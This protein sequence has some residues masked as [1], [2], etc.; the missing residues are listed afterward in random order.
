MAKI[1]KILAPTDLSD[2]SA[3]GVTY[4][5]NLAK[6]LGADVILLNVATVDETSASDSG[7]IEKQKKLLDEFLTRHARDIGSALKI[8]AVV[9]MGPAYI[10]IV[11]VAKNE[12]VDLIVMST[13][14]RSGLPRMLLGSVTERVLRSAL[15]P[16]LAVPSRH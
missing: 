10:S 1:K 16:V 11:E 8:R 4:A 7:L 5:F 3:D 14:G 6:D 2:V 9:D 15:C 13:H 12:S